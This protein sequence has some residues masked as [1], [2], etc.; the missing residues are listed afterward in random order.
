MN[1]D[2]CQGIQNIQGKNHAPK[3]DSLISFKFQR[4]Y[5]KLILSTEIS[6]NFNIFLNFALVLNIQYLRSDIA[7]VF[8]VI[9]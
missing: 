1:H 3:D 5:V 4:N 9:T 8:Y 2:I 7:Q 6:C